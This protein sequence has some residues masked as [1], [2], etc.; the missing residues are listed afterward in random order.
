[1]IKEAP[2]INT[3]KIDTFEKQFPERKK[4]I[5][6][7]KL[8]RVNIDE[9]C[10][11]DIESKNGF[12]ITNTED[13]DK[14]TGTRTVDGLYSPL[15]GIDT[16]TDKVTDESFH[17]ECGNLTGGIN[18][19]DICQ[20]CGTSVQFEDSSLAVTGY[21]SIG[22]YAI[23]T[24][25]SYFMLEKLISGKELDSIIK[26]N[27]RYNM[28]GKKVSGSTK[29]SPYNGI[30]LT[31]FYN[32]FDEIIEYY[33]NKRKRYDVYDNII[34]F[35]DSVFTHNVNVYSSLLRPL[36]KSGSKI[37]MFEVNKHYSVILSNAN[38]IK[39]N[40]FSSEIDGVPSSKV[41]KESI[42]E[43]C[44][45]ETQT[46]YLR[47]GDEI[48]DICSS[49]K[50]VFRGMLCSQRVDF[51]SRSVVTPSVGLCVNEVAIPYITGC[52]LLRPLI[53]KSL[54]SMENINIREANTMIDNALRKF[55]KKIWI[56]MNHIIR[57]SENPPMYMI[58]R[59]PSLLQESIRLMNIKLVKADINDLTLNVPI[60]I[61]SGM[62]ADFDGDTF[63]QIMIFDNRLKNIWSQVHSPIN[64]FIS[65]HSGKY[66]GQCVFV[67]DTCVTLSEIW[68]IGKNNVYYNKWA[69]DEERSEYIN[70]I[71]G[72]II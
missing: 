59:S 38:T 13:T 8:V 40:S 6:S 2:R 28:N 26:F 55:S 49:K 11:K 69:S 1:M 10:K 15:F 63:S 18:E 16:F 62:N 32:R 12:Y 66:S 9:E 33:K 24:P 41:S 42:I 44:L 72:E 39:S 47:I 22:D 50:G 34:N 30:G 43:N 48:T 20:V 65:R 45:Y 35:R 29:A 23:I 53:I 3:F 37:Q 21:I 61:C 68:E 4:K 54:S 52:E 64:N 51:S 36:I 17:C 31:E 60:G 70:R 14:R 71:N 57:N 56:I 67:K 25:S 58:Q 7:V 46:E 19:G 27:N 5:K